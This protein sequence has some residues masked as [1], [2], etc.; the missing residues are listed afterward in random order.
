MIK[1]ILAT[2]FFVLAIL[3]R[4]KIKIPAE[5]R[6]RGVFSAGSM[7]ER[8]KGLSDIEY[9]FPDLDGREVYVVFGFTSVKFKG[10]LS[11]LR[12]P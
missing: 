8:S 6:A 7:C 11:V 10:V 5:K 3:S 12:M 1:S 2:L 9:G 4:Y